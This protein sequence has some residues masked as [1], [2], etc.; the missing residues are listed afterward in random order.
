MSKVVYFTVGVGNDADEAISTV[1]RKLKPVY[2]DR[3][4]PASRS[5]DTSRRFYVEMADFANLTKSLSA[6]KKVPGV[7]DVEAAEERF[8]IE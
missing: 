5:P 6:L 2:V 4:F 7:V 3:L 8:L 1:K